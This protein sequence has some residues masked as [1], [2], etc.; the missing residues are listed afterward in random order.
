MLSRLVYIRNSCP[1]SP[2]QIEDHQIHSPPTLVSSLLPPQSSS[3][4]T[5]PLKKKNPEIQYQIL[6][7][8]LFLQRLYIYQKPEDRIFPPAPAKERSPD[9]KTHDEKN[10]SH[11]KRQKDR[12]IFGTKRKKVAIISTINNIKKASVTSNVKSPMR[13]IISTT[14]AKTSQLPTASQLTNSPTHL[15]QKDTHTPHPSTHPSM[16]G[17]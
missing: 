5:L 3:T 14:D 10:S 1:R 9:K 15:Y 17:F 7:I 16:Q 12:E 4:L 13:Y 2:K 6:T 11:T 8:P